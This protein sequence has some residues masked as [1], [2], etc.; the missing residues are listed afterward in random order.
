MIQSILCNIDMQAQDQTTESELYITEAKGG[1]W[2]KGHWQ[3]ANR[4][5]Q[6]L[7]CGQALQT[8]LV[9]V[10]TSCRLIV[11]IRASITLLRAKQQLYLQKQ[12][13]II[14]QSTVRGWL[15]SGLRISSFLASIVAHLRWI[16]FPYPIG[17]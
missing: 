4:G 8:G 14:L 6:W 5:S 10:M 13:Y 7:D 11:T 1:R 17:Y 3:M 12:V 9:A 16:E 2:M 15:K